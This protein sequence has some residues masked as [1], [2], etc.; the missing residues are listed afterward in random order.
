M[1]FTFDFNNAIHSIELPITQEECEMY[2]IEKW[3]STSLGPNFNLRRNITQDIKNLCMQ[4]GGGVGASYDPPWLD[5]PFVLRSWPMGDFAKIKA[6]YDIL[7][8][9][10]K[11]TIAQTNREIIPNIQPVIQPIIQ[12]A[13]NNNTCSICMENPITTAIIPCGHTFCSNCIHTT[14]TC[15][16]CRVQIGSKLRI[17]I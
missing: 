16:I 7:Q 10:I 5:I 8:T 17:F 12:Q 2:A 14:N 11:K 4:G 6:K 15:H 1:L 13:N 9:I 3:G